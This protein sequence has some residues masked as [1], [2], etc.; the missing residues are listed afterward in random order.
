[1]ST[2]KFQQL[3]GI[4]QNKDLT[5]EAWSSRLFVAEIRGS[6]QKLENLK[7]NMLIQTFALQNWK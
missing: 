4:T 3:E 1:M 6:F 5:F 7:I 2:K